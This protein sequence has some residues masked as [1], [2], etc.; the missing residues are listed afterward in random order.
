MKKLLKFIAYIF[1][2]IISLLGL[3]IVVLKLIPDTQYNQWITQAAE[4]A[5][6][7]E[8]SIANLELDFGSAFRVRADDV[9]ISNAPWGSQ[10]EMLKIERLEA[11]FGLLALL[12][13]TADIRAIVTNANV[14]TEN[15]ADGISNWQIGTKDDTETP[16][17]TAVDTDTSG[18]GLPLHP[19]IR[20]IRID[21][22]KLTVIQ[23][24]DATPKVAVIQHLLIETPEKD[25]T[26]ALKAD[27]NGRS[28]EL[29][30]NLGNMQQ[31]LDQ[32]SQP[33]QLNGDLFGNTLAI[34]GNWGPL[35]PAQ[36][37]DIDI[38]LEVPDTRSLTE[39]AGLQL[40]S[41]GALAINGT[42]TGRDDLLAIDPL[43][44]SLGGSNVDISIS[45][46]VKDLKNTAGIDITA[47][48]NSQ[49][50]Q[51]LLTQ[52]NIKT[53]YEIP[54]DV[55]LH[56]R[57]EGSVEDI[58]MSNLV[59]TV[60]D[61]GLDLTAKASIGDLLHTQEIT[62]TLNGT[63]DTLLRVSKYTGVDLPDLGKIEIS[64]D[65]ASQDKSLQLDNLSA[66]L[67]SDNINF[68][69]SGQIADLLTVRGIDTQA[70]LE[71]DSLT[72]QNIA[73]LSAMLKQFELELPV[74]ILP[75]SINFK[76]LIQGDLEKLSLND[77]Q[78]EVQDKGLK[79]ALDGGIDN[80]LD[81]TGL[82]VNVILN[83]ESV[84]IFSKYTDSELPELGPLQA[85]ATLLGEGTHYQLE[86][87]SLSLDDEVLKADLLAS[88]DDLVALS[89]VDARLTAS[90]AS[91]DMISDLAQ[92]ELPVTDPVE[93]NIKL[94]EDASG[95]PNVNLLV[96]TGDARVS[97]QGTLESL[98]V[99]DSLE[100]LVAL[101]A[102]NMTDF[103][104]ITQYEFTS[105][106]PL[107]LNAKLY[108]EKNNFA[109]NEIK[110]SLNDQS[111]KGA[112][113]LQLPA[114]EGEVTVVNGN[115]DIDY[116]NLT[117]LIPEPTPIPIEEGTPEQ[118]AAGT[119]TD[120]DPMT[121]V[122]SE[123]AEIEAIATLPQER[124][125]SS[126]PILLTKLH[127]Y[128]VDVS[129]NANQIDF[130]KTDL[131]SVL[132]ELK[133]KQGLLTLEPIQ[134]SGGAGDVKGYL[135]ING[136]KLPPELDVDIVIQQ[137]PMPRLGGKLDLN[138]DITGKGESVAELMGSLNGQALLV[139]KDGQIEN[140]LA[141]SFGTGL[142]SFSGTKEYT[143]LECAILR[144]DIV[145]GLADFENKLAAQLSDV[146]WRGGGEINLK[147]EKLEVGIQPKPRKG[148]PISAGSLASLVYIGGT[149]KHPKAMLN[150]T[151]VA[152]KY[153]K[154]SAYVATGGLSFV[155]E[156]IKNKMQANQDV[157]EKILNGTV[158]GEEG[159]DPET[160]AAKSDTDS[161]NPEQLNADKTETSKTVE[162]KK[163]K[164]KNAPQGKQ[165]F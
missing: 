160:E 26:L 35:L 48:A 99:P 46:A 43:S 68:T 49:T 144:V 164:K 2:G 111:G 103:N 75:Q 91:L 71:I 151:D 5:T 54:P 114:N 44:I 31:F 165:Y 131:K 121:R 25:T 116:L 3:L 118:A 73:G 83:S 76:A 110:F 159:E 20:E 78:A 148:I 66:R 80:L 146:T 86:S 141:S 125:F 100:M 33:M 72:Q 64:G 150:P 147:T 55:A 122:D 127:E 57:I 140:S 158:F 12:S 10:K 14:L 52:L 15:S 106:G 6:G 63:I 98:A 88:I 38:N 96:Q 60:K 156:A 16:T 11:D 163:P 162:Q 152:V 155:A 89:G 13:A 29:S 70:A 142:L 81:T 126:E 50:L 69:L 40:D 9:S 108:L 95:K 28:L 94:T 90:V 124:L 137:V 85:R 101:T 120:V 36:I 109:V 104:K 18:T 149:L 7:R 30:G 74:D 128:D 65:I 23:T 67:I 97:A 136:N 17:E 133:L 24:P 129:I 42:L 132:L 39:I 62:G 41:L 1:A 79:V 138:L 21:D 119:T 61:E 58:A 8:V 135:R 51:Q 45:G 37:L 53:P 153:A 145:D 59:L 27:V 134:A 77:I 32:A 82:K 161:T 22:L 19:F 112:L 157:C 154:Y 105:E 34:S 113:S 93:V 117:A 47:D 4:S 92:T 102:E 130:G 107:D 56:A 139:I 84:A 115:I 143:E 87:L 123:N